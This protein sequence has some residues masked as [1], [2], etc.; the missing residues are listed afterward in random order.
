MSYLSMPIMMC[1]S[2]D[3]LFDKL[4]CS[5]WGSLW[6]VDLFLFAGRRRPTRCALVSGF[7]TC[8]LPICSGLGSGAVIVMDDSTCM[9]RA[10]HRIARRWE[11][12]GVGKEC[13]RTCRFRLSRYR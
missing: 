7:Q 4:L 11:E 12:R 8:A 10:C 6:Y 5:M 1:V 2:Y 9:V 3:F 13:V